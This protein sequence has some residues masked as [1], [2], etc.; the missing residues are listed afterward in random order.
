VTARFK[1]HLATLA[2]AP[3]LLCAAFAPA[4]AADTAPATLAVVRV[5]DEV[6]QGML[7]LLRKADE[8]Y[9][10]RDA[11]AMASF[12]A[13]D[14]STTVSGQHVKG[15][16]NILAFFTAMYKTLPAG[17]SHRTVLRRAERIGDLYATDND[18]FLEVPDGAGG[19]R[20]V[21]QFFTFT[22]VREGL[23]GW[24]IVAVRAT[25]LAAPVA[26]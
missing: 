1:M 20:V 11:A 19:K 6:P 3:T 8:A 12:Y 24:E 16:E 10:R 7:D 26:R 25:P 4:H 23:A 15:K 9:D 13:Q 2:L 17:L 14:A 22:I 21:R 5:P 18:V